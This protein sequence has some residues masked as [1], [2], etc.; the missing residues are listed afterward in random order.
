M[1]IVLLISVIRMS[2]GLNGLNPLEI[3]DYFAYLSKSI[4]ISKAHTS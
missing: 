3:L 4:V 2:A 1:V